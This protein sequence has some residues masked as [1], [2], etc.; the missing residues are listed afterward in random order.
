MYGH[1]TS[2]FNNFDAIKIFILE[3]LL[4]IHRVK[5]GN[6]QESQPSKGANPPFTMTSMTSDRRASPRRGQVPPF[7]MTSDQRAG[8]LREQIPPFTHDL[9]RTIHRAIIETS[10]STS[11]KEVLRFKDIE[12]EIGRHIVGLLLEDWEIERIRPR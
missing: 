6:Q 11:I 2:L 7:T 4:N 1:V 3:V 12:P 9:F 8:P 5:H 10:R